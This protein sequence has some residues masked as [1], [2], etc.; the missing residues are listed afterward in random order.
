MT[1]FFARSL[2][3]AAALAACGVAQAQSSVTLYGIVSEDL[4]HAS[5][6]PT[7]SINKLE[8]GRLN[9]A[10]IGFKGGEDLGGGLSAIFGIE[11]AISPDTGTAGAPFWNRGSYVGLKS[12][13]GTVTIG[14]Q[15]NVNDDLLGNFFIFGGYAVFSYTGLGETSDIF[16]NAVK[17]ASPSFGGFSVEALG[18]LGEGGPKTLEFGGN[19]DGGPLKAVLTYHQTEGTSG[20]K[21]KLTSAGVSYGM[22]AWNLRFAYATANNELSAPAAPKVSSF[23]IGFDYTMG[24]A[25]VSIDYVTRDLKDSSDDSNFFRVLGKYNLSKRT[26]LNAN[27]IVLKNKGAATESFY[28]ISGG[29]LKQTV[30]GV[31]MSHAF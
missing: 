18:A 17:Y 2:F 10:R 29:G 3:S 27:A 8:P 11:S 13:L 30:F 12:G 26:Q 6:T 22:S 21:D 4:V 14:R 15:W 16:N 25:G 31:G 19:Y 23:D 28:G 9:P 7:G 1:T 24:P 20:L 5:N